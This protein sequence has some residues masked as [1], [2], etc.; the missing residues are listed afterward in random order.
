MKPFTDIPNFEKLC[1]LIKKSDQDPE[2]LSY[3]H[4]MMELEG[5][6]ERHAWMLHNRPDELP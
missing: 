5:Y 4:E 3:I 6:N 1:E 2:N